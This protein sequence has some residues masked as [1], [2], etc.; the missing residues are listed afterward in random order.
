MKEKPVESRVLHKDYFRSW[1]GLKLYYHLWP[2]DKRSNPLFLILHGFGEHSL[3]YSELVEVLSCF[4]VSFAALDLRGH[5]RSEGERVYI[6]RFEDY[7]QDIEKFLKY[8]NDVHGFPTDKILLLG[9]SMGGAIAACYAITRPTQLDL[10][11]LSSPCM[12]VELWIP[13]AEKLV[14]FLGYWFPHLVI[15][16]PVRPALLTHDQKEILQYKQDP[17]IQRKIT[18]GLLREMIRA[19]HVVRERA[20]EIRVPLYVLAAGREYIVK[21]S[22]AKDFFNH[23]SSPE[24]KWVEFD[25]FYHEILKESEKEKVFVVMKSILEKYLNE[26]TLPS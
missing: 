1:D 15:Y 23:V 14:A 4:P 11:I 16:N 13:F 17:F 10:L 7:L 21:K 3:R 2:T 25:G 12:A 18:L 19:S 8:L 9:H 20:R 22:A 24:K 26:R 5:G 6:E